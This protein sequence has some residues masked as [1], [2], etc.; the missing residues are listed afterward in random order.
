[1]TT[2]ISLHERRLRQIF[3]G[4]GYRFV[5]TDDMPPPSEVAVVP[6]TTHIVYHR[7]GVD[8]TPVLERLL[9]EQR[10]SLGR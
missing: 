2:V 6:V 4:K 9:R 1:M 8:L 10:A 3:E 5:Q 7:A